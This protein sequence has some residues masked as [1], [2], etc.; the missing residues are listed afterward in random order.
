MNLKRELGG[1]WSLLLKYVLSGT[2][3]SL[4]CLRQTQPNEMGIPSHPVI[5]VLPSRNRLKEMGDD[6]PEFLLPM[7][8]LKIHFLYNTIEYCEFSQEL[9]CLQGG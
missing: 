6:L 3:L 5:F 1:E 2:S 9:C 4:W 7:H 8:F